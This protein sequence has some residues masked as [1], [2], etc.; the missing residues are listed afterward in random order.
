MARGLDGL[1]RD[2]DLGTR[3]KSS[4]STHKTAWLGSAGVAGW[5][6]SRLPA[7]NKKVIVHADGGAGKEIKRAVEGGLLL[8]ILKMLVTVFRPFIVNFATQ[9][10]A[11]Y[12]AKKERTGR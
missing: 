6:L 8:G 2:A 4:F 1:R 11:D 3:F 10:V 9:L 12:T 5:L 7:R